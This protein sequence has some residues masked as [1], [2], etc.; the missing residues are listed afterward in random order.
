MTPA[1]SFIHTLL[2]TSSTPWKNVQEALE[3]L[4]NTGVLPLSPDPLTWSGE[5]TDVFHCL[6]ATVV[7][8]LNGDD[9]LQDLAR[10]IAV[11]SDHY[12]GFHGP[13]FVSFITKY[14]GQEALTQPRAELNKQSVVA[15]FVQR[16]FNEYTKEWAS[17]LEWMELLPIEA[18]SD[19]A[20]ENYSNGVYPF[21]PYI[22]A[23]VR[24]EG[25][26]EQRRLENILV[27]SGVNFTKWTLSEN[28]PVISLWCTKGLW[29]Q[30]L[31]L[32]GDPE[33][34]VDE[35]GG[36]PLWK[37]WM[38]HC[39]ENNDEASVALR[40][41]LDVWCAD[42]KR[43]VAEVVEQAYFTRLNN[44]LR[45]NHKPQH[46]RE[47]LT[48]VANWYALKDSEGRTPMMLVM[49][50][51]K[52]AHRNFSAK[53]YHP[54]LSARDN[55]GRNLL[56]YAMDAQ[57]RHADRVDM[58]SFVF[59]HAAL[60]HVAP[61]G[62]GL[63]EQMD[64]W[65]NKGL[66][67]VEQYLLNSDQVDDN[68]YMTQQ[69]NLFFGA[70]DHHDHTA[71][72]IV[73]RY[74]EDL[75]SAA[76]IARLVKLGLHHHIQNP[77]LL[78]ALELCVAASFHAHV[79]QYLQRFSWKPTEMLDPSQD[80]LQIINNRKLQSYVN[81]LED[82]GQTQASLSLTPTQQH[83]WHAVLPLQQAA[84]VHQHVDLNMLMDRWQQ[85]VLHQSLNCSQPSSSKTRKI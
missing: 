54:Y 66:R 64:E 3:L 8:R 10:D 63:I 39:I 46:I 19:I 21:L 31:A 35:A 43:N 71:Q 27:K 70:E 80:R 59:N 16:R 50:K 22:F 51:H 82:L 49:D 18:F 24:R 23:Q 25:A 75:P 55:A 20:V 4:H 77:N 42:N 60:L 13:A 78:A 34:N 74:H 15:Q 81:L 58:A 9:R 72:I 67:G 53:K 61:D 44:A 1:V 69:V 11:R 2:S 37:H 47:V 28:T 5:Q 41:E 45:Y 56:A 17:V 83:Q 14:F 32:G 73:Q 65:G 85:R 36:Q 40:R 33:V 6:C 68:P 12:N 29:K 48:S 52:N 62:K 76:G 84:L 79:K 57:H 30:Y 26:Q 38:E 7:H